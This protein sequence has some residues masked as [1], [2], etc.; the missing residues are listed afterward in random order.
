[1]AG[2]VLARRAGHGAWSRPTVSSKDAAMGAHVEWV[3]AATTRVA[4]ASPGK[5]EDSHGTENDRHALV[6]AG[7]DEVVIEGTPTELKALVERMLRL[8]P[9]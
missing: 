1:M 2:G 3:D 7:G 6:L 4:F 9:H 8:L 5:I